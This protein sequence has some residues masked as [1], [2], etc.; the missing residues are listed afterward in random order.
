MC[1]PFC[2]YSIHKS[3][4][5]LTILT[6]VRFICIFT[7]VVQP[8]SIFQKGHEFVKRMLSNN[9]IAFAFC[10]HAAADFSEMKLS[11]FGNE[12]VINAI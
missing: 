12:I 3:L 4:Y 7:Q 5:N 8:T 1:I 10:N 11:L 9:E 2:I 6:T